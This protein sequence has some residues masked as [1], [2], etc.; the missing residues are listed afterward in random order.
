MYVPTIVVVFLYRLLALYSYLPC[1][2]TQIQ[3][4]KS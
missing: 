4:S 2:K 1:S 3:Y